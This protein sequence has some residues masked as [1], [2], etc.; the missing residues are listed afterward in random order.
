MSPGFP[1][2]NPDYSK[3]SWLIQLPPGKFI[4]MK[5]LTFELFD[6]SRSDKLTIYNGGSDASPIIGEFY[7]DEL[8]FESFISVGHEILLVF[9][10]DGSNNHPRFLLEYKTLSKPFINS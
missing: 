3:V 9:R 1:N 6:T 10:S 8:P 2:K 5:F 7:G 4:E